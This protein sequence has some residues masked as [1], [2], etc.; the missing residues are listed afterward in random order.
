[1]HCRF[2]GSHPRAS[3]PWRWWYSPNFRTSLGRLARLIFGGEVTNNLPVARY[4]GKQ[5]YAALVVRIKGS[6]CHLDLQ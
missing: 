1:M 6:F 2:S 4:F 5:A 3:P